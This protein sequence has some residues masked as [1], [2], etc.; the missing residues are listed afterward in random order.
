MGTIVETLV[1]LAVKL[2]VDDREAAASPRV[3]RGCI[4]W[5]ATSVSSSVSVEVGPRCSYI[6]V[7]VLNEDAEAIATA[8]ASVVDG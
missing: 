7:R 6:T 3:N 8:L 2:G 5:A 4:N 1:P